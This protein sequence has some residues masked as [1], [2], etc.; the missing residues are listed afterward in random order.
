MAEK[1]DRN[2]TIGVA[3]T[4]VGVALSIL[5]ALWAHFAGLPELDEFGREL[6]PHIPR[7]NPAWIS[8]LIGQLVSLGGLLL[9]MAGIALAYLYEKPMTWAR[10]AV[11][12]GLFT[13]LMMILFGVIP[14]QWL[15]YTQA[16]WEWTDQK[17]WFG[18]DP[19]ALISIPSGLVGGNSLSLSAAAVKDIIAGTY[20]VVAI[21]GVA[22]AMIAWQKRDEIR[23][24]RQK[25]KA[26]KGK[27]SVYGRPLQKVER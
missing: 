5:G 23:D 14:N 18:T 3:A 16:V 8:P 26:E 11:G 22:V 10:S 2:T 27:T 9:A 17:L 13:G 1:R 7:G 20:S 15:T 25:A 6:Y 21:G 24:K 19:N 12:A 4:V